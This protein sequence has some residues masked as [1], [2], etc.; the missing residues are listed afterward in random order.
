MARKMK[1]RNVGVVKCKDMTMN[2][3]DSQGIPGS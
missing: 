2:T 3:K 1:N